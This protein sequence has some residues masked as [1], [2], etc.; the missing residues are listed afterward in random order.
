MGFNFHQSTIFKDALDTEFRFFDV[1]QAQ[2]QPSYQTLI[3]FFVID[4]QIT[5]QAISF[6]RQ[7]VNCRQLI[8]IQVD[9]QVDKEILALADNVIYCRDNQ[10]EN[11]FKAFDMMLADY[12]FIYLNAMDVEYF[13]QKNRY[14]LF[15]EYCQTGQNIAD[16]IDNNLK[17]VLSRKPNSKV[18]GVLIVEIAQSEVY[19]LENHGQVIQGIVNSGL[20]TENDDILTAINFQEAENI[21]KDGEIGHY[22]KV[23]FGFN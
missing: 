17:K 19:G 12:G 3:T 1:Y 18:N 2:S 8:A 14:L 5:S 9:E 20:L 10:V 13:L 11:V 16:L 7:Q 23:F 21:W 6:Y 22:L 15:V 4:N